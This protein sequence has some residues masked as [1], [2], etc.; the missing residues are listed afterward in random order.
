MALLSTV[1]TYYV[2]GA[3]NYSDYSPLKCVMVQTGGSATLTAAAAGIFQSA[4]SAKLGCGANEFHLTSI[5]VSPTLPTTTAELCIYAGKTKIAQL[6]T[7]TTAPFSIS[8]GPTGFVVPEVTTTN[9]V[10]LISNVGGCTAVFAA[11]GYYEV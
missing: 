9:A 6:A 11:T 1:G 2:P 4:S 5:V 10:S 3:S 8:F 7:G